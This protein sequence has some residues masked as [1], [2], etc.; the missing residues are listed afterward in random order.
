M[1]TILLQIYPEYTKYTDVSITFIDS[2]SQITMK[3]H[4]IILALQS[5]YFD[6]L[7]N[8]RKIF[9]KNISPLR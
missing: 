9:P 1:N 5:E 8:F 4:R 6:T 2:I 7:F 3:L